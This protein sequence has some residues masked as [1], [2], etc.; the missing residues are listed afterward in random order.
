MRRIQNLVEIDKEFEDIKKSFNSHKKL[1][2]KLPDRI[3]DAVDYINGIIKYI[4]DDYSH[5]NDHI[6]NIKQRIQKAE[7]INW[8]SKIGIGVSIGLGLLALGG[9]IISIGQNLFTASIN[10]I[11]TAGN[12]FALKKNYESYELSKKVISGL[13]ERLKK[14]IKL[15]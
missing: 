14:A 6:N 9:S 11:S 2:E 12:A 10:G 1:L 4:Q 15:G 7:D 3:S 8:K 5:L 13:N